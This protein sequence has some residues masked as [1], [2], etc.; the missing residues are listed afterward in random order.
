MIFSTIFVLIFLSPFF[1]NAS[2][3]IL[4][5]SFVY[6]FKN[7]IGFGA[8]LSLMINGAWC[9]EQMAKENRNSSMSYSFCIA[10]PRRTRWRFMPCQNAS[11]QCL[12]DPLPPFLPCAKKAA[13]KTK[14]LSIELDG[15]YYDGNE[16][17]LQFKNAF[18]LTQRLF[19]PNSILEA[20][21]E[22]KLQRLGIEKNEKFIAIHIR[23]G[24]STVEKGGW[25]PVTYFLQ[26]ARRLT[27]KYGLKKPAVIYVA[28]DT[29]DVLPLI[30]S[31]ARTDQFKIVFESNQ[32][33]YN[34]THDTAA[35]L[36]A[37]KTL[38][39]LVDDPTQHTFELITDMMMM[40]RSTAFIGT[41]NS[42]I[43]RTVA[44]L[45]AGVACTFADVETQLEKLQIND[46]RLDLYANTT[47]DIPVDRQGPY[48]LAQ[49]WPAF[50][51]T[52]PEPR[53]WTGERLNATQLLAYNPFWWWRSKL[54]GRSMKYTKSNIEFLKEERKAINR[55]MRKNNKN[56][57]D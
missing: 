11:L 1:M 41:L 2:E 55:K 35:D 8:E 32:L 42:N 23:R 40:W 19:R 38:A 56:K 13:R 28:T 37:L 39:Y 25:I 53:P 17:L 27:S 48:P 18:R 54:Y 47:F 15:R 6:S 34:L 12:F 33:R 5:H 14:R 57:I 45:R 22:A 16:H 30:E 9:V 44:E 46:T 51:G 24:D 43:G 10:L 49:M 21:Y 29:A 31:L 20:A 3:S 52:F 4:E 36:A 50:F 26:Q 7:G